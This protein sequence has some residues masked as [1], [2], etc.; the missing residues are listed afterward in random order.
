ML[1]KISDS[2]TYGKTI[3]KLAVFD[4]VEVI[5]LVTLLT[6]IVM[7]ET[8]VNPQKSKLCRIIEE[9]LPGASIVATSRK[10]FQDELGMD[11]INQV[12]P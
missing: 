5:S 1:I 10:Y 3:H 11:Y 4:P 8:T 12:V 6:E 7:P 9:N 2:Q